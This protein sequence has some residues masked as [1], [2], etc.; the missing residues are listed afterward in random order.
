MPGENRSN[1]PARSVSLDCSLM[2]TRAEVHDQL[3]E[4]L[5][6]PEWYGRNLDA[7]F[8]CLNEASDLR[9]VVEHPDALASLGGYGD[10]LLNTLAEAA[11]ANPGLEVVVEQG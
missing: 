1:K 11:E 3:A 10:L 7:L 9:I 5:A 6:L 2:A 4:R 8:D